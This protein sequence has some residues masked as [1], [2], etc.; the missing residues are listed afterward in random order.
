MTASSD[1]VKNGIDPVKLT[2]REVGSKSSKMALFICLKAAALLLSVVLIN[3]FNSGLFNRHISAKHL[4]S[5][6]KSS[7]RLSLLSMSVKNSSPLN[8]DDEDNENNTNDKGGFLI[9]EIDG[10]DN[11]KTGQFIVNKKGGD[12][13]LVPLFA[14]STPPAQS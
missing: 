12:G 5:E 10:G 14:F 1:D 11:Q 9:K 6:S 8:D 2:P 3:S 7:A 4:N 13:D